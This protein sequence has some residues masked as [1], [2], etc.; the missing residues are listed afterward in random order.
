VEFTIKHVSTKKE[1]YTP[2]HLEVKYLG[3]FLFQCPASPQWKHFP[4]GLAFVAL[5]SDLFTYVATCLP[6]CL[7]P[8]FFSP[9]SA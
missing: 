7:V 5:L 6:A 9:H 8:F 3:Q 1:E 4:F 2:W